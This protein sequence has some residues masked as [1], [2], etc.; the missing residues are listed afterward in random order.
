MNDSKHTPGPW[1]FGNSHESQRI[2]LGGNRK[3]VA[4]VTIHQV[5][6]QMGLIDEKEREANAV[7][8]TAAPEMLE[9]L[10]KVPLFR[11]TEDALGW[12]CCGCGAVAGITE[13]GKDRNEPCKEGCY[14]AIVE[15]AIAKA[16]GEAP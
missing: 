13:D 10:S 2:I 16:K 1:R 15:A 3:Y 7:L 14:V 9:A 12:E 11:M 6:R 5:P 4:T 8:I